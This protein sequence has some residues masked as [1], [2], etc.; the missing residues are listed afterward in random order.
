LDTVY[1]WHGC[2]STDAERQAA[3]EYAARISAG[4]ANAIQL[5][6]D[7][8]DQDELFW[9][10]LG[11]DDFAKADYWQWRRQ[12]SDVDP[13]IWRVDARA[14]PPVCFLHIPSEY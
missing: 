10:A 8:N 9:M 5:Y 1:V 4:G 14:D 11:D 6:E 3:A 2:G 13:R 7:K 12:A